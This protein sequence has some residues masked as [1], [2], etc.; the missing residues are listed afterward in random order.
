MHYSNKECVAILYRKTPVAPSAANKIPVAR[1][2]F[3]VSPLREKNIACPPSAG[4]RC[5]MGTIL[6]TEVCT[7]LLLLLRTWEVSAVKLDS[8]RDDKS[9]ATKIQPCIANM[10]HLGRAILTNYHRV[11]PLP[12]E[13]R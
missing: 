10:G 8:R 11:Q 5:Q 12:D 7:E 9:K 2:Q 3:E 4:E 6:S 13:R 1:F